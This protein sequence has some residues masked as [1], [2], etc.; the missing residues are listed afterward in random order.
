M[1]KLYKEGLIELYGED[2]IIDYINDNTAEEIFEMYLNLLKNENRDNTKSLYAFENYL[3]KHYDTIS[4]PDIKR[5][6]DN[7]LK[8]V[9][10]AVDFNNIPNVHALAESSSFLKSTLTREDYIDK[11]ASNEK[12]ES[13]RKTKSALLYYGKSISD[14]FEKYFD[15]KNSL[16]INGEDYKNNQELENLKLSDEEKKL[17]LNFFS[18]YN[19]QNNE[20]KFNE[21]MEK[22]FVDLISDPYN[23]ESSVIE[24]ELLVRYAISNF[25]VLESVGMPEIGIINDNDQKG[26][27]GVAQGQSF[28][29]VNANSNLNETNLD[30]IQTACHEYEHLVQY[31]R[32]KKGAQYNDLGYYYMIYALPNNYVDHNEYDTNY[33]YMEIELDAEKTA[34]KKLHIYLEPL[35]EKYN[36]D[37]SKLKYRINKME[38]NVNKRRPLFNSRKQLDN[39]SVPNCYYNIEMLKKIVSSKPEIILEYPILKEIFNEDGTIKNIDEFLYNEQKYN[40]I[41]SDYIV[42]EVYLNNLN[43]IDL[44]NKNS[45]QVENF[46]NNISKAFA[47]VTSMLKDFVSNPDN[48]S[49]ENA[50]NSFVDLFNDVG[51]FVNVI[52]SNFESV[53]SNNLTPK[54]F[55]SIKSVLKI[56]DDNIEKLESSLVNENINSGYYLIVKNIFEKLSDIDKKYDKYRF[57]TELEERRNFIIENNLSDVSNALVENLKQK[58]LN[59]NADLL[60]YRFKLFDNVEVSVEEFL[61]NY[62]KKY[63]IGDEILL[64]DY[65]KVSIQQYLSY[66]NNQLIRTKELDSMVSGEEMQHDSTDF[67]R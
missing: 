32:S 47:E 55:Y 48:L 46:W 8:M 31:S 11:F 12:A 61:D 35:F 41:V 53:R 67:H 54:L 3:I 66:L 42:S 6:F 25:Y 27:G 57:D 16:M 37:I 65:G 36:L 58:I 49:K 7:I 13:I 64:K 50:T 56:Y 1:N 21:I 9:Y 4:N 24:K 38:E 15:K 44:S 5:K 17:L 45:K 40:K 29:T 26:L 2:V 19:P 43:Q 20:D 39:T 14:K 63:L 34:N 22:Y 51:R 30:I 33:E 60:N 52:N 28:I 62:A 23:N 18:I 10:D 59:S